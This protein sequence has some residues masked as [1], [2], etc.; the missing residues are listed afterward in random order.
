MY[1]PEASGPGQHSR[2]ST[3]NDA[4]PNIV[5]NFTVTDVQGVLLMCAQQQIDTDAYSGCTFAPG[6]TLDDLMTTIIRTIH[7]E[8]RKDETGQK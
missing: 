4:R 1:Q 8:Q 6:R 7:A 3:L 5:Y 2:P